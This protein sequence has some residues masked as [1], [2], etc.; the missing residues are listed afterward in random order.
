MI[1]TVKDRRTIREYTSKDI[2]S[3]LLNELLETSFRASTMGGMQLYSVVVTRDKE[4]KEKLAPLH[5]NQ[6]MVKGAPVLLTFCA[7]YNRFTQWCEQRHADAGYNNLISFINATTDA[8]LVAQT[9]CTLAE[10]AGLGICYLGTTI[11]NPQE[12]IDLLHLPKLVFPV[13]TVTVGYP[14]SIPVQPDRLPIQS[15]IHEEVYK[16]YTEAAID[17][18]YAEK[19][20]LEENK[21]FIKENKKENLAQVFTDIRYTK[22]DNEAMSD[23][24]LKVLRKQGFLREE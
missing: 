13:A 7:D 17:C 4:M 1:K 16:A 21:Q 6:P 18:C 20:S 2:P 3:D 10:E 9:F 19:E 22:K 24:I 5:F 14:Q 8:L 23:N 12:I 15:I 11:Y